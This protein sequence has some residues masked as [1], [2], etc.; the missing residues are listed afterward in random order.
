MRRGLYPSTWPPLALILESQVE[1]SWLHQ[2]IVRR[3]GQEGG[4]EERMEGE[5]GEEERMEVEGGKK[6]ELCSSTCWQ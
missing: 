6:K 1:K 2:T 3:G 5:G 4:E